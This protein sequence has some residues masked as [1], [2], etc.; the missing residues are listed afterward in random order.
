MNSPQEFL[1]KW[2]PVVAD[3]RNELATDLAGVAKSWAKLHDALAEAVEILEHSDPPKGG[4]T[5]KFIKR[6]K[7]ALRG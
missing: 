5:D 3:R 7:K 2:C 4:R 1:A 6:A